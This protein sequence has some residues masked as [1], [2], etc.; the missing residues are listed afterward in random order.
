VA[1]SYDLFAALAGDLTRERTA[2]GMQAAIARAAT[3][4]LS[5]N[6]AILMLLANG[7]LALLDFGS[8]GRIDAGLRAGLQRLLVAVDRGDPV[9]LNDALLDR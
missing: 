7:Q 5:P 8:G 9:A 2:A 1:R 3:M 6:G 4:L